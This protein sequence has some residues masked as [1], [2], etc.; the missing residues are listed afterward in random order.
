LEDRV[1]RARRG[2]VS[3]SEWRELA[4]HLAECA[5][6][7]LAW[8]LAKDFDQSAAVRPGDDRLLESLA[9]RALEK[10]EPRR[11]WGLRWA[12]A[13]ALLL[14]A[15]GVASGAMLWRWHDRAVA[16][17]SATTV[18]NA[19]PKRS[20]VSDRAKDNPRDQATV[21]GGTSESVAEPEPTESLVESVVEGTPLPASPLRRGRKLAVQGPL[22]AS[23]D[24]GSIAPSPQTETAHGLLAQ[25]MREREQGR[26]QS[27]LSSLRSLRAIYPASPEAGVALVSMGNLLWGEDEATLALPLF[28]QYLREFPQGHLVPEAMAGKARAL[29]RLGR[30][31]DARALW[32]ELARLFPNSIYVKP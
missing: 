16:R 21:P 9:K 25:A 5:D 24:A 12:V 18:A 4:D 27:A 19:L 32:L 17:T 3:P 29:V 30:E 7:R 2:Q 1:S 14:S 6:C 20:G 13:A 8:R 26:A 28:D 22:P 23:L 31:I 10:A 15:G 11:V